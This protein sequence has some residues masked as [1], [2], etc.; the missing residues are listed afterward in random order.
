MRNRMVWIGLLGIMLVVGCAEMQ[1]VA[2]DAARKSGN[3]RLAN[4]IHGTGAVVAGLLP[5][6]YEEEKSI[7]EAIALQVVARYGGTVDQPE[8]VRYVNLVGKAVANASDRPDIAYHMAVLN[9]DSINAFAAPA[10]YIFV[11]RGLL[12]Q[13]QNEAELA[14]VLGHEIAHVSRKHI[15][16]VIQRSKQIAGI[17]EAGLAYASANPAVFKNVIDNAVKKLLDEGLDQDKETEA[18]ALGDVFAARVGYDPSAYVGLLTRLRTLKGDDQ[19]FFKTHPNFSSRI[20]AVQEV[21]RTK[22]LQPTGVV[23]PERFARRA[24]N[25]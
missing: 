23:L 11:T 19:A 12:K 14:A 22:G 4:A 18:D 25:I 16:D 6:G 2:E 15:L 1:R 17:S 13:I 21:I 9:H 3:P 5:I 7:G 10:G 8:L 20:S 24:K